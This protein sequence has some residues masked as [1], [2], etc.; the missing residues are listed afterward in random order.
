MGQIVTPS[1]KAG[2]FYCFN[3]ELLKNTGKDNSN[4]YYQS[5]VKHNLTCI[6]KA[7]INKKLQM[8]FSEG[9]KIMISIINHVLVNI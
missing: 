4:Q 5:F 9:T 8:L 1:L 7:F 2:S 6:P 3:Q